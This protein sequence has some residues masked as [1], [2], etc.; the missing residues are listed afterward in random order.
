M[1]DWRKLGWRID[2]AAR[3]LLLAFFLLVGFPLGFAAHSRLRHTETLLLAAVA[4]CAALCR[5]CWG[6]REGKREKGSRV[7]IVMRIEKIRS[8]LERK[9]TLRDAGGKAQRKQHALHCGKE[10]AG[11]AATRG[12]G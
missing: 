8:S 1:F 2:I 3:I 10:Q 9:R 12:D 11:V 7:D 5:R 6:E 4:P